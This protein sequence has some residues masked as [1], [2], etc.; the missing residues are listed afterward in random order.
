MKPD[1]SNYEVWFIDWLDGRLNESQIA[2]LKRFLKENPDLSGEIEALPQ[3]ELKPEDSVFQG[4]DRLMK[5]TGSYSESQFEYLCVAYLENDLSSD[6][7]A[8]LMEIINQDREKK[9]VFDLICSL[10][11]SPEE[12]HFPRKSIVKRLTIPQKIF[13]LSV[14]GLSAAAAIAILITGYI[15][16]KPHAELK[17]DL[18]AIGSVNDTLVIRSAPALKAMRSDE[19]V[20]VTKI[21]S[22][23]VNERSSGTKNGNILAGNENQL[24][25]LTFEKD[26]IRDN[27]ILNI[28]EIHYPDGF[29]LNSWLFPNTIAGYN[30]GI[31]PPTY[32]PYGRRSNVDRFIARVFHEIL[33][34]DR[35]A[36]DRPIGSFELAEAGIIGLNKLLGWGMVLQQNPEGGKDPK[37]FRFSSRLVK[38][39]VPVRKIS[40]IM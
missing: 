37:S 30:P 17:S 11:L 27:T 29:K 20:K 26:S 28:A 39:N 25:R 19:R 21:I 38:I 6:Q 2:D 31:M 1:R 23:P 32:D 4:K 5:S 33:M 24:A 22:V 40:D 34:K 9:K 12:V 16:L 35:P 14:T 10:K 3:L 7:S 8:E 13:R 15:L 36:G 18:T